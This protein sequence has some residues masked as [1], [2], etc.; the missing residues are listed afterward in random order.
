[1]NAPALPL[2][3]GWRRFLPGLLVLSLVLNGFLL[4]VLGGHWGQHLRGGPAWAQ[5]FQGLAADLPAPE[6][7]VLRREMGQALVE[8]APVLRALG[9]TRQDAATRAAAPHLDQAAL[10]ADFTR[11]RQQT[12]QAQAIL[13]THLLHA[14]AQLPPD[15]RARL[16]QAMAR[17]LS[18]QTLNGD[19]THD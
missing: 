9:Q 3:R 5:Q 17:R 6:R 19:S 2:R 1:M 8:M 15:Q 4:G 16:A 7:Q 13:Q 14:L 10:A 11:L 18:A 12:N